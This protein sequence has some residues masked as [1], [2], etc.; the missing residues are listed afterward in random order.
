MSN[1]NKVA[2]GFALRP[3]VIALAFLLFVTAS[4]RFVNAQ[5]ITEGFENLGA[6][7]DTKEWFD[8]N[9]SEPLNFASG[10]WFQCTGTQIAPAHQGT[11]NSCISANFAAG[12]DTSTLSVWLLGPNRTF[13]NGDTISF[14]TREIAANPYPNRLQVRLSTNGL[15]SEIGT[16]AT[17]VGDFTT[18][19]LDINPTYQVGGYPETWTQFTATVSGLQ[20]PTSGRFAFRYFVENGGPDGD[21]S[22]IIGIDTLSYTPHAPTAPPQH[23]VDFNGDGKSDYAVARNEGGGAQ[24]QVEWYVNMNGGAT[25]CGPNPNSLC[26]PFGLASDVVV[27]ADYD[28]DG[29]T[30]IAVWRGGPPDGGYFYIL[31]SSTGNFRPEQFGQDGDDPT[32]VG[33]YTGD[34]KADPAVFRE[35]AV[36]GDFSYWHYK[37][38]SGPL[39]GQVVTTHFGQNGDFPSPGDYDGDG[40]NDFCVQRNAG[41][42]FGVFYIHKGTGGPDVQVQG[43]DQSYIFG[44]PSDVIVPGD[45]DGDGKTDIATVHG[46]GGQ[47]EWN[48]RPS[49]TGVGIGFSPTYIFGASQTDYPVVGDYDGDGKLDAAVW[50]PDADPDRNFFY[51]IGSQNGSPMTP[52]EWGE[53][54]DVPVANFNTH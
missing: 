37:A 53:L 28:G 6:L 38:S 46:S 13:N 33:D 26:Q 40:K 51:V 14:Y 54:T 34:G 11:V 49:S 2:H 44:R 48:I 30:D 39:A 7:L 4:T 25:P 19:L 18:L 22:Y 27:P 31:E 43:E 5:A 45:W 1:K 52:V 15:S 12:L 24:G 41:G 9:H 3:I 47:I 23:I 21:N 20:G 36:A 10:G 50:R 16:S 8:L 32:V 35:G 29:K 17:D 42:G